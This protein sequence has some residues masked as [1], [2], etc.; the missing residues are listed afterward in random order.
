[1]NNPNFTVNDFFCGA[2][3]LGLGFKQAGFD[4]VGAWD[5]NAFA[6]QSYKHNLN[7]VAEVADINEMTVADVP[8]A[9][10][11]T[12]GFPCQDL[13]NANPDGQGL[14]G[15]RS[16]LFFEVM[17]L[18]EETRQINPDNMPKL[19][20]AENVKGLKK[21]L[22]TLEKEY[23]LQGYK[24][25]YTIINSE[26]YSVP[27]SRNRYFVVG[28]RYDLNHR[29]FNFP[30]VSDNR[31]VLT[32]GDI[33]QPEED[34]KPKFYLSEK[35]IAYMSRERRGKPRWEYHVNKVGGVAAT[36]TANMWKGVPYGVIQGLPEYRR[37]TPRECARLQGFPDSYEIV[38]SD[39]QAYMMF[40]NGVT[41][42]VAKALAQEI[43]WFLQIV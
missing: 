39:T 19:I 33:L 11:W 7:E 41:V 30:T 17:R 35:A 21:Y 10:V 43:K 24:M 23:A 36:L 14:A 29:L 38:T 40:G 25:L 31:C 6:V 12:F 1:M 20:M 26:D 9:D 15:S 16:G 28:I 13:S 8:K 32:V 22:P 5:N 18:L 42:T 2:G 37:F 27:Q 34:I 4:T 3:G